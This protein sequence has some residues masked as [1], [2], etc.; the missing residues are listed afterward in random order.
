[1]II[2]YFFGVLNFRKKLIFNGIFC[3]EFP[4]FSIERI[5]QSLRNILLGEM[6]IRGKQQQ[7][8]NTKEYNETL[9]KKNQVAS[10]KHF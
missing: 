3:H 8:E 9:K 6:L 5:C 4:I 2:Q 10:K 7:L 1:V